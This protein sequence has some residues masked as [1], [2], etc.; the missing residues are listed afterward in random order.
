MSHSV[1]GSYQRIL[2]DYALGDK[3]QQD[4]YYILFFVYRHLCFPFAA[5]SLR[6][7]ISAN[8]ITFI[9]FVLFIISYGTLVSGIYNAIFLGSCWYFLAFILDFADGTVARFHNKPN[10]FG[11]LIDGLVDYFQHSIYLFIGIGLY[12]G[13]NPYLLG[14]NWVVLGASTTGLVHLILYFRMRVA[15]FTKEIELIE[16]ISVKSKPI[17]NQTDNNQLLSK[18]NWLIA[19]I[20]IAWAPLFVAFSFYGM[21]DIF[22]V[23]ASMFYFLL[24]FFEIP[25]RLFRLNSFSQ[26]TRKL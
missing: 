14:I 7:G 17:E 3:K 24:V 22:L 18:L 21:A 8:T 15:Y 16:G 9:G 26:V 6:L 10:Y 12:F 20:I 23:A 25:L 5:L 11:K 13:E 2:K 1:W 4:K 19:N